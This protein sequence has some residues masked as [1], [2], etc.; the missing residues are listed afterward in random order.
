MRKLIFTILSA[1]AIGS[2]ATSANAQMVG[3]F[4]NSQVDWNE[5]VEHTAREEQE[6]KELWSKLQ[7]K[8]VTCENLSDGQLGVLGEYF[9]GQMT[10]ASH[11][12][13]NA[14]M[15]QAHGEDGEEQIHI[16]MGKR[17]SGCDASAA[18]PAISGGWMPMM[19]MMWGGW[20]FD[21][22]QDR[23]SPFGNNP[24]NNTMMNFGF[25][26]FGGFGWIFM[27]L[28]WVLIIAGIVAL[29]KWLTSQSR[30]THNQERTTLDILK[31]RYAKG[32]I[33]KKEFEEKKKDLA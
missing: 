19:N 11:A 15:I 29:I 8:E 32:E 21:G 18:F 33:D 10:G 28:W 22:A 24:T 20:S 13:M 7:A 23:S 14:M 2:F 25:G 12:A 31:G 26:P 16:V 1:A 5:V 30:D 3:E 4:S 27:I 6:G 9:M 17:L